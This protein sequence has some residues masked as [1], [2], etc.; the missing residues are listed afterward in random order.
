MSTVAKM[1]KIRQGHRAYASKILGNV[2]SVIQNYDSSNESRLRQLN[3]SL[4]KRLKKLKTLDEEILEEVE[5]SEITSEIEESGEINENICGAIVEIDS[6]LSKIKLHQQLENN[7]DSLI[8]EAGSLSQSNG[9]KN[10]H[11]KL[12]KL[13]LNTFYGEPIN[14]RHLWNCFESA[15]HKNDELSK[16]DILI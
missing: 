11:A 1:K 14:G 3:I 4:E 7:G 8:G 5:D 10:K 15:V 9:S 16:V 2:K 13:V 6:V 12:P